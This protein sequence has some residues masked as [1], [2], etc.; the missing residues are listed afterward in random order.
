MYCTYKFLKGGLRGAQNFY[1]ELRKYRR[2]FSPHLSM[3]LST[4]PH[5]SAA[6]P[7][8]SERR[9]YDTL[10]IANTVMFPTGKSGRKISRFPGN[11]CRDPGKFFTLVSVSVIYSIIPT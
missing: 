7:S 5:M 1:G 11:L 6:W 10:V 3:P 4:R 9:F 2:G 8:G